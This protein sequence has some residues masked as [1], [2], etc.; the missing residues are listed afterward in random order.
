M[1][2]QIEAMS[3]RKIQKDRKKDELKWCRF[4]QFV[5]QRLVEAVQGRKFGCLQIIQINVFEEEMEKFYPNKLCYG[6]I[7]GKRL[8]ITW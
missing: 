8:K 4:L 5:L 2:R 3:K 7:F 1:V 6:A